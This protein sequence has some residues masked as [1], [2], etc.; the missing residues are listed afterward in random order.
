MLARAVTPIGAGAGEYQVPWEA[1]G[2]HVYYGGEGRYLY[3]PIPSSGC[4]NVRPLLHELEGLVETDTGSERNGDQSKFP[5]A[6][7][8]SPEQQRD[9]YEGRTNTFKFV[10]VQNPYTRLAN[11]YRDKIQ[12]DRP[13]FVKQIRRAAA[14]QCAALGEAIGFEEFVRIVSSQNIKDMDSHWRPQYHEGR[15]ATIR[16]DFVGREERV[17]DDLIY[18]LERIGTPDA[19]IDKAT[20]RSKP[21]E[22]ELAIWRG[23]SPD[24]RGM[25]LD[26]FAI[27]FEV[28]RYPHRLPSAG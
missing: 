20:E 15:F 9:L 25:F 13:Y 17:P 2:C 12:A 10:I 3:Q 24:V 27:D 1:V 8:L 7:H 28:L 4:A 21:R 16:F 14:E 11:V 6:S 5:D 22:P 26:R 23:V 18:A 19:V